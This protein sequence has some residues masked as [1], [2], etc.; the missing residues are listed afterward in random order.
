MSDLKIAKLSE[1]EIKEIKHLE[2]LIGV[3]L[4][5]YLEENNDYANLDQESV[6]K[7]KALE[8]KLGILLLAYP[9]DK[10]A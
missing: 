10:A 3:S 4:V 1:G 9:E 6:K 7:I 8:N 2:K 5:A